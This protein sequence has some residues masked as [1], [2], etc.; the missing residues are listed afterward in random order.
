MSRDA[1]SVLLEGPWTHRFVSAGGT[2]F[3][4]A[5][6][7]EGPLV[8]LLHGFPQFWYA[9][10][11]Q[12]VALADAGYRAAAMDLRGTAPPTSP[13]AG[14]PPTPARPT[15]PASSAPS[16]RSRPSSSGRARRVH[17]LV[18][19]D[20]PARRRA[21]RRVAVDAAPAG[22]P[23]GVVPRPHQRRAN[24][25]L[26]ELQ[27]PFRPERAMAS[28]RT[29]SPRSCAS[30]PRRTAASPP[31]RTCSGTPTRWPC[32]SSPTP[33][34]STTGGSAAASCARTA[35]CSTSGSSRRCASRSC[36]SRA[37][38]TGA[39]CPRPTYGRSGATPPAATRSTWSRARGTSSPRRR[40]GGLQPAARLAGRLPRP[41]R[42][43]VTPVAPPPRLPEDGSLRWS[44]CVTGRT[45]RRSGRTSRPG[46]CAPRASGR[47]CCCSRST[48][49]SPREPRLDDP[50]RR[51]DDVVRDSGLWHTLSAPTLS[52]GDLCVLVG[53]VSDNLATNALLRV[54]GLD[55]VDRVRAGLGLVGTGLHDEVRGARGGGHPATLSTGRADELVRL[56]RGGGGAPRVRA[57]L[58]G[59]ADLSM[60][61]GALGLDPLSRTGG[62]PADVSPWPTRRGPTTASA[63]TS[64]VVGRTGRGRASYAV[65]AGW[66][67][68]RRPHRRGADGDARRR[69]LAARVL[70]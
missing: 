29:T 62:R 46:C 63:P 55:A 61:A 50:V 59:G 22:G 2:R 39:S 51:P 26:L 69:Q 33:R 57:W 58:E 18:G 70:P 52:V 64:A 27:L 43:D 68:R 4:V 48:A 17:R 20:A 10:R 65:V 41:R 53:S 38:T 37:P 14:T 54:V 67:R 35:R 25:Y 3:H 16:A 32:R 28:G 30:G 56:V 11:H 47:S 1:A 12:L 34:R 24:R 60:V 21:R 36:S 15:P 5:E 13:R 23:A 66:T 6:L 9:W 45:A 44:A 19:A 40:G 49:G 42:T 8:L 31:T 7:G